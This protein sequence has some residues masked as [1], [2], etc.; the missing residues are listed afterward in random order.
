MRKIRPELLRRNTCSAKR[1]NRPES[2]WEKAHLRLLVCGGRSFV[3]RELLRRVLD[4]VHAAWAIAEI[5]EGGARSADS[6]AGEWADDH[7]VLRTTVV[8]NWEERGRALSDAIYRA[9]FDGP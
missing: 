1:K 7:R 5:I 4:R 3:N 8:A 9:G 6:L 2:V